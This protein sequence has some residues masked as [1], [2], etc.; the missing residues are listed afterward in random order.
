MQFSFGPS[1][2]LLILLVVGVA[3]G[4]FFL[5][6]RQRY[7]KSLRDQGWT[8]E[9]SPTLERSYGLN[10]PPFGLG[11]RRKIDDLITGSTSSG[12]PF[13]VFEYGSLGYLAALVLPRPLPE[14][15][16]GP[17]LRPG[18]AGQQKTV[19]RWT[20]TASDA[21]WAEAALGSILGAAEAMAAAGHRVDL[22]VDGARLVALGVPREAAAMRSFLEALAPIAQALASPDLARFE[23][24]APPS[25]LSIYGRPDWIYRPADDRFLG[26][27]VATQGG[28]G[29]E[30]RDVVLGTVQGIR[31]IGLTHDWKT[32]RTET[33]TDSNGNT[34]TRTVTD[35]HSEDILE[36]HLPWRFG[37]LSVNWPGWGNRVRFESSDFDR[38]FKVRSPQPKFA[39]DVFHPRQ[40]E[41]LLRAQP[42]PFAVE[43]GR[44]RFA[45]NGNT[46]ERIMHCADFLVAFFAG[47]P[48]FVWAD[49]GHT[50]P[51]ISR[52]LDGF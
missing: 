17:V 47:V 34:S 43:S 9:G 29:H 24:P 26:E 12:V 36:F 30:A 23:A 44:V 2:I 28:Y 27:V 7:V 33:T 1:Q 6:R 21:S 8:F 22:S 42:L 37:D 11:Y 35:N 51:P 31:M 14:L 16:L 39:S 40:L 4:A 41:F 25:E 50:E 10:C 15:Y 46:P 20:A 38:A 49:L 18:A 3:V 5:V 52:D 19:G 13:A 48:G 32:D 45:L